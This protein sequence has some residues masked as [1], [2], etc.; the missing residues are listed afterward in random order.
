[1]KKVEFS[2]LIVELRHD[3]IIHASL[4]EDFE[5]VDLEAMKKF[6]EVIKEFGGGKKLKVIIEIASFN[7]MTEEAKNYSASEES[8]LYT[9]ANAIVINSFAAK[10]SA[11]FFIKFNKPARPTRIFNTVD[12][13][14]EWLNLIP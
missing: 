8:Q 6:T 14:V 2:P 3:D 1:M 11:N 7:T 10:L 12:E 9:K 5:D 4:K 13:A